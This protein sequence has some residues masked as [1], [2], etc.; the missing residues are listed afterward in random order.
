MI[1]A[2]FRTF[3]VSLYI[4]VFIITLLRADFEF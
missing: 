2:W 1:D 4:N 3:N